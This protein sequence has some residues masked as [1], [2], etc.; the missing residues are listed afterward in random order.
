MASSQTCFRNR[1]KGAIKGERSFLKHG[2]SSLDLWAPLFADGLKRRA[3]R[4]GGGETA[5]PPRGKRRILSAI[6]VDPASRSMVYITGRSR[7]FV[8][9]MCR[10]TM[11]VVIDRCWYNKSLLVGGI[12][13]AC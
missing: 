12:Q 5:L 6:E 11:C 7:V 9:F 10:V 8:P 3:L 13:R 1:S 2:A 4:L